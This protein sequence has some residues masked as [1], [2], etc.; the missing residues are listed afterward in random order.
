[1]RVFVVSDMEGV[2]GIVKWQQT[3]GG[4]AMYEEA[5]R[6]YDETLLTEVLGE[7]G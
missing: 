7:K 4:D 3:K 2:A 5:R 1:M 6:L